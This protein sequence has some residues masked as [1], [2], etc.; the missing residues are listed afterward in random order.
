MNKFEQVPTEN[1]EKS[2]A[3]KANSIVNSLH[4]ISSNY[5]IDTARVSNKL[6]K[7]TDEI[8]EKHNL[9]KSSANQVLIGEM[10]MKNA[11]ARIAQDFGGNL[12]SKPHLEDR[13]LEILFHE[14]MTKDPKDY[15]EIVGLVKSYDKNGI[16][17]ND[18]KAELVDS[19]AEKLLLN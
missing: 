16:L 2:C 14:I 19:L 13:Y 9:P 6:K 3:D 11:L 8:M 1:W 5:T 7:L 17:D 12:H 10:L 15:G 18:R 4:E